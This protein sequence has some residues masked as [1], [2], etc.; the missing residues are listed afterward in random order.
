[1]SENQSLKLLAIVR[2]KSG[3]TKREFF[4]YH[5]QQH[6]LKS[7]APSGGEETPW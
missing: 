6:G 3:L 4:D 5:F 2:R 1:M 7:E